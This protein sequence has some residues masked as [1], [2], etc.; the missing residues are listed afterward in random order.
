MKKSI[1]IGKVR[2]IDTSG[3]K[4]GDRLILDENIPGHFKVLKKDI[5]Y[6]N[7]IADTISSGAFLLIHIIMIYFA[8]D[9]SNPLVYD[10]ILTIFAMA[11]YFF[12]GRVLI[13]KIKNDG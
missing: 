5:K 1:G 3:F 13:Y 10:I 12:L 4:K 8:D 7:M 11:G 6:H 9:I 2:G